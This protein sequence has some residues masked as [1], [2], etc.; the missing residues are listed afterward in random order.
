MSFLERLHPSL[1]TPGEFEPNWGY[2]VAKRD[3]SGAAWAE[4]YCHP[5]HVAVTTAT[6]ASLKLIRKNQMK[7]GFQKL[8]E[9]RDILL[10]IERTAPDIFH[11]LSRFYYGALAYYHYSIE[12]FP[13]AEEAFDFAHEEVRKA[14]E[15]QSFLMPF[16]SNCFDFS[17]QRIRIVRNQRRWEEMWRRVE[18]AR[19]TAMGE[20]PYC[21]LTDGTEID[22]ASIQAFYRSLEPFSHEEEASLRTVF[23]EAARARD[24]RFALTEIFAVPGFVIPYLPRSTP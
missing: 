14:I 13:A 9:A 8:E 16:A 17:I 23:D 18:I 5:E 15:R 22:L 21:V 7:A 4:H 3:E 2:F 10:P 12:D 19:Q 6:T 1:R 20:R 11:V 24:F